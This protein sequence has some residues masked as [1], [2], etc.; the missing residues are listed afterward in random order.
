VALILDELSYTEEMIKNRKYGTKYIKLKDL[1]LLSK[2]YYYAGSGTREIKKKLKY[3]CK[4]VDRS[5]NETTQGWKINTAIKE[6]KKRRIRTSIP[7]PITKAE[8]EEI[9]KLDNYNLEKILFVLLVYAKIL[10]Y[11]N[12]MVK[13]RK[14]AR[15]LGTFYVNE[16]LSN[17]FEAARVESNK[18][19][20]TE[21][22]HS[23]YEAGYLDATRYG[24]FLLKYIYEESPTEFFV[25][26][27]DD[28]V[29]Y[30]QR[31]CGEQI[32]GCYQCGRLFVK[33]ESRNGLCRV[34]RQEKRREAWKE[35]QKRHRKKD[36]NVSI[37]N[38]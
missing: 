21:M 5:W 1:I 34:C 27:Y 20:R 2:Y 31:Y 35:Q 30:Y 38:V 22:I 23:L 9:K 4:K 32:A 8:L 37:T 26:T 15:I 33:K 36:I 14:R 13:P 28:F 3:L 24:G 12:T 25:E 17:I 10:K 16:T 6:A 19:E 11:N 18:K 7:I 29:L